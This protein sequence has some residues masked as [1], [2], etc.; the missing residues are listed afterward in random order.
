MSV[1]RVAL[2]LIA[3]VAVSSCATVVTV[4]DAR[5]HVASPEFRVY[6]ERVFREQNRLLNELA[7]VLEDSPDAAPL[8]L[9]AEEALIDACGGVNAL[10]TA[11]RDSVKL[12]MRRDLQLARSAPACEL[13]ARQAAA[14]LGRGAP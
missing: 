3:L 9:A 6:V 11:R 10:A 12:G 5:L 13:A 2:L 14:A 7:F 4:D 1:V 8:L